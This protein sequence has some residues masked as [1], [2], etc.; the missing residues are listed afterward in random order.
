MAPI[1]SMNFPPN[2]SVVSYS[3]NT[4]FYQAE[5]K[6]NLKAIQNTIRVPASLYINNLAALNVYQAPIAPVNGTPAKQN[7]TNWNQMSDRRVAHVQPSLVPT[8]GNSRHRTLTGMRPGAGVPGGVG[9][10]IKHNSYERRLNRLKAKGPLRQGV[11]PTNF[12]NPSIPFDRS[13]PVYGGKTLKT[14]IIEANCKCP[15]TKIQTTI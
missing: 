12:A 2:G 3:N 10:D 14:S 4:S 5:K 1:K 15:I 8:N 7:A 9:V 13:V 11:I 6:Q